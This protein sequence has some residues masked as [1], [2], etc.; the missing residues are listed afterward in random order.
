MPLYINAE[1]QPD[2]IHRVLPDVHYIQFNLLPTVTPGEGIVYWDAN[3]GTGVIGLPGGNYNL[4]IGQAMVLPGRVKNTSGSDMSRGQIVYISGVSGQQAIV[5]LAKADVEATSASTIAFLAE[6]IKNNQQGY[7]I[8]QGILIGTT[9]EPIDTSA[10]AVGATLWLSAV[11]AGAYINSMPA[12]PNHAVIVGKVWRSHATEGEIFVKIVNGFE[13][14]ELHDVADGLSAPTAGGL[15]AWNGTNLL[16]EQATNLV[17]NFTTEALAAT[18]LRIGSSATNYVDISATGIALAGT[19]RKHKEI[20]FYPKN[21]EPG[22]SAPAEALRPI[23]ASGNVQKTVLQFSK[24]V[25]QDVYFEIHPDYDQDDT[26]NHKFHIVWVPGSGWTAGNYVWKLEYLVKTEAADLS[27]GAPTTISAD[28]TPTSATT[29]IE[30]IFANTIDLNIGQV[31]YCHFYR[32]VASDNGDDT[33]DV[34]LFESEYTVS[35]LGEAM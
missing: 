16:W 5:S 1:K 21:V 35:T 14:Y 34:N 15:L 25:Q 18:S 27:T 28:V 24:T 26:V 6:D 9:A 31:A 30:T 3:Y 23:G 13:F 32:D 19:A 17:Y 10:Y 4:P 29:T 22:V 2:H 11:T 12:A 8:T 7:A 20:R 33:G